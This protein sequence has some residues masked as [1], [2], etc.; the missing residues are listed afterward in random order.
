MPAAVHIPIRMRVSAASLADHPAA[1]DAAVSRALG[2]ALARSHTEVLAN[3][4]DYLAVHCGAPE[5]KWSGA[6]LPAVAAATRCATERRLATLIATA[7]RA[8]GLDAAAWVQTPLTGRAADSYDPARERSF[9][10]YAVDSYEGGMDA[11]TVRR[12]GST[13]SDDPQVPFVRAWEIATVFEDFDLAYVRQ[14]VQAEAKAQGITLGPVY[15]IL[16]RSADGWTL[17]L[18]GDGFTGSRTFRQTFGKQ[19]RRRPHRKGRGVAYAD[20]ELVPPLT[21]ATVTEVALPSDQAERMDRMHDLFAATIRTELHDLF[22]ASKEQDEH[23]LTPDELGALIEQETEAAVADLARAAGAGAVMLRINWGDIHFN[24]VLPIA[25]AGLIG[26]DGTTPAVILPSV[27]ETQMPGRMAI[28]T[29]VEGTFDP[30]KRKPRAYAGG[31]ERGGGSKFGTDGE[32]AGHSPIR[33]VFPLLGGGSAMV[34]APFLD[35]EP[36]L[37]KLPSDAAYLRQLVA[38]IAER[39]DMVPCDYPATFC[40]GAATVLASLAKV[41]GAFADRSTTGELT[42]PPGSRGAG[43]SGASGGNMGHASFRPVA[44][45]GIQLLRRL[46]QAAAR[47]ADLRRAVRQCYMH[48]DGR[49]QLGDEYAT[50]HVGWVRRFDEAVSPAMKE[51]VGEIF[52]QACQIIMLQLLETSAQQIAARQ[53]NLHVYAPLFR[54]VLV[55]RL[56]DIGTLTNLRDRLR[57]YEVAQTVQAPFGSGVGGTALVGAVATIATWAAA[58]HAMA[59]ACVATEGF[60]HLPGAA[61]EIV[62]ENGVAKIRDAHGFLWS[63]EALERAVVEQRGQ[64]ESIDPLVQQ[65]SDVPGTVERFRRDPD[66]AET[67]LADLLAE[68]ARLNAGKRQEAG[69]DPLYG[70]QVGRIKDPPGPGAQVPGLP[71]VLSGVHL[72]AHEQLY[73]FFRGD[74]AYAEG[75]NHVFSVELGKRGATH[76]FVFTG[77]V[78]LAVVCAPAAFVAGVAAAEHE[79]DKAQARKALYRALINPELVLN[80]AEIELELYIAYVGLALSLLPEAGTALRAASLGLRGAA[81]SGIAVGLRLA[82]RSVARQISR[83]VTEQLARELLPALIQEFTVNLLM[84]HVVIPEVVVPMIAVVERELALR[85]S[86]GGR[87]GAERLIDEIERAA[88]QRAGRAL[89]GETGAAP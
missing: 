72:L 61:Q 26:W 70:L 2:R 71:H 67:M 51:G 48:G 84:E 68:M 75:V 86:V 38:E 23:L 10:R 35:A 60:S 42:L 37:E 25:I 13:R 36:A 28:G 50:N 64:A 1:I 55:R 59:D 85:N 31:G 16:V 41:V 4:G 44:S 65:L 52:A 21:A 76:F 56:S 82:A 20:E 40:V 83:Q 80:R 14:R 81:R 9:G 17:I 3:T 32:G 53:R 57:A 54:D 88:A 63:R 11:I 62:T 87:A 78:L 69:A 27:I 12:P 47:I 15:G 46:S 18:S 74:D 22:D 89:P 33:Q 77:L 39:L 24:I 5:I 29:G 66:S 49:A 43:A 6:A 7:T 19:T 79:V 8:A 73:P 45:R 34:C 58:A 30:S